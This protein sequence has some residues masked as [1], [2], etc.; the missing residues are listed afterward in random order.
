[1]AVSF[2][3]AVAM[4]LVE[5]VRDLPAG[6]EVITADIPHLP[7]GKHLIFEG[8]PNG[9]AYEG[10]SSG[11]AFQGLL[12]LSLMRPEQV[13]GDPFGTDIAGAQNEAGDIAGRF[14]KG[15]RLFEAPATITIYATPT[16]GQ[17]VNDGP[18]LRTQITIPYRAT[19][20]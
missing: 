13:R 19:K 9:T 15:R 12:V 1:M 3:G 7:N 17:S 8:V 18:Y 4:A 16:V 6:Y 5:A 20:T 2:E 10:L 11:E 14:F